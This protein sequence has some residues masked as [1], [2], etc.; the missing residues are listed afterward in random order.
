MDLRLVLV[1]DLIND[2]VRLC[3]N[4]RMNKTDNDNR[5]ERIYSNLTSNRDSRSGTKK[6]HEP[7]RLT[8]PPSLCV[9]AMVASQ[10][11]HMIKE[12]R[13]TRPC[14]PF[15]LLHDATLLLGGPQL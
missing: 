14:V 3:T 11:G 5:L 1:V 4:T 10:M 2:R 12:G 7:R 13:H 15:L 8:Y 6:N 9:V